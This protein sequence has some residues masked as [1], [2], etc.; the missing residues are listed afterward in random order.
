MQLHYSLRFFEK[1]RSLVCKA[2]FDQRK[3]AGEAQLVALLKP[4]LRSV[5][6][7]VK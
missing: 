6:T 4:A 2:S 3:G 5:E 1:L 7:V